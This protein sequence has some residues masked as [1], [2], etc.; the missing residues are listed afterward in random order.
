MERARRPDRAALRD[1]RDTLRQCSRSM[2]AKLRADYLVSLQSKLHG[3]ITEIRRL[4]SIADD[5]QFQIESYDRKELTT[6][7]AKYLIE[8]GVIEVTLDSDE[9]LPSGLSPEG[10]V[11]NYFVRLERE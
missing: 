5:V 3:L 9:L 11:S 10:F 2:A 4:Q 1:R 7:L 6:Q 8:I